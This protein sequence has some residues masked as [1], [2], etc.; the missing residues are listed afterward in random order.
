LGFHCEIHA[1]PVSGSGPI[2]LAERIEE[3]GLPT[4]ITYGHGDTVAGLDEQWTERRTPW[5]MR[6]DGE[7]WYGHLQYAVAARDRWSF[8][9][10]AESLLVQQ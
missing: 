5:T 8:R 10:A 3:A 6:R 2:L 9:R 4:V 7:R 1:N